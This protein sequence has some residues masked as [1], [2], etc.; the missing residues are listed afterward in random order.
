MQFFNQSVLRQR[1]CEGKNGKQWQC[2]D[3]IDGQHFI[4][5]ASHTSAT[6]REVRKQTHDQKKTGR[7]TEGVGEF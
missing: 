5:T 4:S 7:H 6:R 3:D 2:W 1:L